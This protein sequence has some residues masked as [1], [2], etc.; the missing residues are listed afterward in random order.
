[1]S[2]LLLFSFIQFIHF[3]PPSD[4]QLPIPVVHIEHIQGGGE[5][6]NWE[7]S[8]RPDMA[9]RLTSFAVNVIGEVFTVEVDS[10]I[11]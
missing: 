3:Q 8:D 9:Y 2:Y 7:L 6:V 4:Y 10:D 11:R 5:I 1:M